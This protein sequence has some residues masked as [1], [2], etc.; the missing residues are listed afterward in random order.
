MLKFLCKGI[1]ALFSLHFCPILARCCA[2]DV[3]PFFFFLVRFRV[4]LQV[5]LRN[6]GGLAVVG[7]LILTSHRDCFLKLTATAPLIREF[8]AISET[9]DSLYLDLIKFIKTLPREPRIWVVPKPSDLKNI[10]LAQH[11]S[12]H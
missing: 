8:L 1:S 9:K 7:N 12:L 3:L 11:P 6:V 2:A 4:F 5:S 10:H